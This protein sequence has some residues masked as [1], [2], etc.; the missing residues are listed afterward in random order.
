L[1]KKIA[2]T[3]GTKL[4]IAIINLCIA[5]VISNY[6]GASGKGEQGIIITTITLILLFSNIVGGASLVY[7]APRLQARKIIVLSYAWTLLTSIVFIFVLFLFPLTEEKYTAHIVVLACIN[8]F[9]AINSSILLGKENIR[10]NNLI[11]FFQIFITILSLLFFLIFMDLRNVYAYIYSLYIAYAASYIISIIFL[12][13]YLK[14]KTKTEDDTYAHAVKLLFRFGFV[15]QLSHIAQLM[16]FRISYYFLDFYHGYE[17]VGIYS[18]GVSITESVWMISGSI[19]LVQYSKIANTNDAKANQ[20]LTAELVRI[21][22]LVTFLV[23]IPLVLLPS[24]FYSFI[25]GKDFYDINRIIWCLAPGMLVYVNSLILGHY[26]SGTGKYHINTIGSTIGLAVT[27]ILALMLIPKYGYMGSAVTATASYFTTSLFIIIYFCYKTQT[28][29]S[30]LLPLPKN[31][32]E[33]I[34]LLKQHFSGKAKS[35][36]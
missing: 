8:S 22:L 3:F 36:E 28:K 24:S 30:A 20:K 26:F 1:F 11:S 10:A 15:N 27:L 35:N 6:L 21:S 13:P 14:T 7:L 17:S 2:N 29:F 18:N 12:L 16:S 34:Y 23:L 25:F 32:S 5:I 31:I 4:I 33:Y 9:T 19:A